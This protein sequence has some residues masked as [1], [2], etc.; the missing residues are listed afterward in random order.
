MLVDTPIVA[1]RSGGNIEALQEGR[2]GVLVAP[3]DPHAL[4]VGALDLLSD[5]NRYAALAAAARAHALGHF[6]E[7]RHAEAVMALYDEL[8]PSA[9]PNNRSRGGSAPAPVSLP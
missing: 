9:R 4:A 6:G 3:E 2:L 1:S 7:D 5:K 8:V